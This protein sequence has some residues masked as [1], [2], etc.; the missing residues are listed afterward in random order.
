LIG[1]GIYNGIGSDANK[2]GI[3]NK[4]LFRLVY[5]RVGIILRLKIVSANRWALA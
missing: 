3:E 2:N 4:G 1:H 5:N